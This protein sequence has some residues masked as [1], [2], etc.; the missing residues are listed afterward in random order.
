MIEVDL[1]SFAWFAANTFPLQQLRGPIALQA[2]APALVNMRG[3]AQQTQISATMEM[4]PD[5]SE[6]IANFIGSIDSILSPDEGFFQNRTLTP[7]EI[8]VLHEGIKEIARCLRDESKH[9]YV[10][11]LEDQRCLSAYTL[12][13]RIENCFSVETWKSIGADAKQELEESG[14]CLAF[15]RYTGS[16][17]HA[18]RG[19][20]CVMRQYFEK[21]TGSRPPSSPW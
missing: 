4:L 10:M 19:V 3:V 21:L 8:S 6:K 14:K 1:Y 18:L 17:F 7:Q 15:E 20:E 13:E 16:A 5:T 11:C 9:L 2:I 12:I